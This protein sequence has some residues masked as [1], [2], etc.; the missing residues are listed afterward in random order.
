MLDLRVVVTSL[1][2]EWVVHISSW[3]TP[4]YDH[5]RAHKD[6]L[7]PNIIQTHLRVAFESGAPVTMFSM[8]MASC[9]FWA[10]KSAFVRGVKFKG[11]GTV[12]SRSLRAHL[13]TV[14]DNGLDIILLDSSEG[15]LPDFRNLAKDV[16][17]LASS[18]TWRQEPEL[19]EI[20][21]TEALSMVVLQFNWWSVDSTAVHSLCSILLS[22][23]LK[24]MSHQDCTTLASVFVSQKEA[25]LVAT[26]SSG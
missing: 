7:C 19:A 3:R 12:P 8:D 4:E 20:L 24:L 9:M 17:V 25:L 16:D 21:A 18:V 26:R 13:R 14:K 6:F 11:V 22:R 23:E 5:L 10:A 1:S 2:P 15:M